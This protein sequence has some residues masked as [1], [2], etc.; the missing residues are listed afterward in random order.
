M[1]CLNGRK[2]LRALVFVIPLHGIVSIRLPQMPYRTDG[3]ENADAGENA[4][5]D[6]GNGDRPEKKLLLLIE[7]LVLGPFFCVQQG[8]IGAE[9]KRLGQKLPDHSYVDQPIF[10]LDLAPDPIVQFSATESSGIIHLSLSNH[11]GWNAAPLLP[12]TLQL[13]R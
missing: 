11:T 4:S 7:E 3:C 12:V 13:L 5:Q 6:R 2:E 1:G 10:M 8:G 9:E